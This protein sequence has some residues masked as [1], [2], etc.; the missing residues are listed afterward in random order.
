MFDKAEMMEWEGKPLLIKTDYKQAKLH[1]KPLVKAHDTYMQ[2]SGGSTAG[3]NKYNS[4]NNIAN[5]GNEI[6][7]YIAKIMSASITNNDAL[8]NIHNTGKTK[9]M[10]IEAMSAQL[11]L[12]A[13]TVAHLTK[14]IKPC[15]KNCD[16]NKGRSRRACGG[17][18]KQITKL[19]NMGGY[20][21]THM[22]IILLE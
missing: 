17:E 12:L 18:N 3:Q 13:D 4:A 5:I 21:H 11:K 19:C 1:F 10:Q 22:A 14:S 16:P 6:K 15:N 9:D 2:N 20:C 8:A 7:D